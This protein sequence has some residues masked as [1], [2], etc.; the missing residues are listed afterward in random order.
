[1]VMEATTVTGPAKNLI[2]FCKTACVP[3]DCEP[4]LPV[5]KPL[6]LTY[7]RGPEARNAF[8]TALDSAGIA[9]D[10]I[11][12][13]FR[14]DP[15]ILRQL[16]SHITAAGPDLIQ[17]HNVKSHLLVRAAGLHK[18]YPWV[19]FHHGYTSTDRK[20]ELYNRLD[21][22]SLPHARRVVTV[23]KPFG[24]E[25]AAHGV[26]A[27]KIEIVHNSVRTP[28][29]VENHMLAE[30]RQRLSIEKREALLLTIGRL[31]REKGHLD[32]LHAVARL[33]QM[34]EGS[35]K[36]VIAGDGPERSGLLERIR[37]LGLGQTVALAGYVADVAPLYALATIVVV[38]SHSEGSPNVVLE[39][40]VRGVPIVATS[41]GGVPEILTDNENGL[42]VPA[43]DPTAMANAIGRL[44]TD[45]DL[46]RRLGAAGRIRALDFTPTAYR[47]SLSNIYL[48][49][50]DGR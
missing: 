47:R 35:F 40:T 31:S 26:S 41:V 22:W 6:V 44:L 23:C 8:V 24:S 14:F 37:A 39:A 21:R 5:I 28:S 32:L 11:A 49:V 10:V 18:R 7:L 17:T 3:D 50:L 16:R 13:K 43:R 45:E 9:T 29:A 20:M 33:R 36:L 12:E 34:S 4:D 48:E 19:A 46:R 25:L 1:M 27:A 38:P 15:G 42:L 30:W 2:E